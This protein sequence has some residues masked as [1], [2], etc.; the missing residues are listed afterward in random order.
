M[1]VFAA[2]FCFLSFL[3]GFFS[4]EAATQPLREPTQEEIDGLIARSVDF[5][6]ELFTREYGE[7]FNMFEMEGKSFAHTLRG[8]RMSSSLIHSHR[9]FCHSDRNIFR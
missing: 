1:V 2:K 5:Y 6:T 3:I 8:H 7:D 9:A 4:G